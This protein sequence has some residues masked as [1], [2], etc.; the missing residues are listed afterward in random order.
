MKTITEQQINDWAEQI[1]GAGSDFEASS[2]E[3]CDKAR[4]VFDAQV[5]M[6]I[7]AVAAAF[8]LTTTQ[9]YDSMTSRY[10][11][12]WGVDED[13]DEESKFQ[14][15]VSNHKMRY[16]GPVTSIETTNSAK[17]VKIGIQTIIEEAENAT[18]QQA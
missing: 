16:S 17:L 1:A 2:V 14:I 15:R 12:F 10:V 6:M 9:D 8:E 3:D 13:G 18:C 5:D 7:N 4:E 11:D